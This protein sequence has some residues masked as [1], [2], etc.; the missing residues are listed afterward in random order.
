M[1]NFLNYI[2][3]RWGRGILSYFRLLGRIMSFVAYFFGAKMLFLTLFSTWKRDVVFKENQGFDPKEWFNR[4]LLNFF[5]RIIGFFVRFITLLIFLVFEIFCLTFFLVFFPVWFF[6]PLI[7]I[8]LFFYL[9]ILSK[10]LFF[11]QNPLD[12]PLLALF[13]ATVLAESTL[14]VI[15]FKTAKTIRLLKMLEIDPQQPRVKDPWFQALCSHLLIEENELS[16]ALLNGEKQ[17]ILNF[18]HL[19][20][21]DFSSF[22]SFEIEKQINDLEKLIWFSPKNLFS[23]RPITEDW[24]YGWTFTLNQFSFDLNRKTDHSDYF[25]KGPELESLKSVLESEDGTNVV[26]SGEPGTGRQELIESLALDINRNKAPMKLMGKRILE[27]RIEDLL[28]GSHLPEEKIYLLEKA[29]FE[30]ANAGNIILFIPSLNS[31]L[32]T[33]KNE[34]QIGKIDVSTILINFLENANIKIIT[35]ATPQEVNDLNQKK[36]G[37]A[38]YLKFVA[39]KEP[40]EEISLQIIAEKSRKLEEKF[41]KLITYS[42]LKRT[43]EVCERYLDQPAMPRRAIT[44]LEEVVNFNQNNHP[45][46][47]IVKEKEVD[48][49]ASA[50]IGIKLGNIDQEEK[51]KL[52]NLESSME[53]KIIGQKPAIKAVVSALKRRRLDLSNPGRPAGCFLFLGPTGV[54][55]THTAETLAKLYFGGENLMARLDMSEYQGED[56]LLKLLGDSSGQIEGYF[57]K[58]LSKNPFNLILL[59]E[60]EKASK[61]VHQLLL[62]IMEEGMAKTGSGEK[63]NFRESIII[64]TSNAES[65]L[66]IDL[67]EQKKTQKEIQKEVLKQI[68]KNNIFS[69]ELLNRFDEAIM[70]HPVSP[71]DNL[72]IAGLAL[73]DLLNRLK[74]KNII[75]E[76]SSSFEQKLASFAEN[77]PFGAREIRRIVQKEIETRLAEDLLAGKIK[78]GEVFKVPL[79]YLQNV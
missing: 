29:L 53:Q 62:Q 66:I 44:F 57:H 28:S 79:E 35:T 50:K 8:F 24:F 1:K 54:G 2:L 20:E 48:E 51:M 77:S 23:K 34:N 67:F 26:V 68:Y 63:L 16:S 31:Y 49:Y 6:S 38:K 56:A 3:F 18:S 65:N 19:K 46:D 9:A 59:D 42:A 40:S 7:I 45:G 72:K 36:P 58:I 78:K 61:I 21:E 60:L 52:E 55:K 22:I 32:S 12:S 37:I 43:L 17:K 11:G 76:F 75:V 27:F 30:S 69:P 71:E 74:E 33:E 10:D 5:S 47:H 73:K 4:H 64:A 70:F 14:L 25:F 41:H 15:E 13:L 39:L